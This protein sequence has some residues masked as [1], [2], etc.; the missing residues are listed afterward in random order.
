MACLAITGAMKLTPTAAMEV[1]LNLTPLYLFIMAEARMALYRLHIL[2]QPTVPKTLSGLLAIC[3]NL[4]D[5]LLDMQS[6]YTIPVYGHSKIIS[7]I[8]DQDYW[9]KKDPVLP[10]DALIWFIHGSRA[11]SGTGSGIYGIRP[12]R[13]FSFPWAKFAMVFQTR[14]YAILQRACENIRRAYKHKWIPI[15]SDSQAALKALSSLKVTSGL[16][17]ECLDALSALASLTELTSGGVPGHCGNS[18]NEEADKLARQASAMSLLGPELALGIP[19]CSAR[20]AIT[21]WTEY[22]HI[23]PRKVYQVIDM[24]NFLLV[25]HVTKELK[26]C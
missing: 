24:A 16:V 14:I 18:G 9:R 7:V 20:E 12:N 1:L 19:T 21:H 17:A 13:S 5:P 4:D 22:Q 11:A 3:K 6:D 2:E 23:L 26:T 15:F 10:E 8:I 25:D